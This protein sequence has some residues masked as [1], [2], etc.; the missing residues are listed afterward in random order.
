MW[1]CTGNTASII[2]SADTMTSTG[3]RCQISRLMYA[4]IPIAPNMAK[5]GMNPK[6]L[7]YLMGHSDISVTMNVYTHIGFDDA[8]EE[9]KR[10]EEFR[11]AQA[12]VEQKKEKPMS[13]KMFKVV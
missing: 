11:K 10:M 8:E 12:E 1:Q 3:C 4:D 5:S 7:Q 13:Q 9:L 2:W 6:T